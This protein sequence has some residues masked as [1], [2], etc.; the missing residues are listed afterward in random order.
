MDWDT[1]FKKQIIKSNNHSLNNITGLK[2]I[3]Y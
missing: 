3:I 2:E 1:Y